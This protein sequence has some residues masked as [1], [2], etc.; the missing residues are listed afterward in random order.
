M[1]RL[2]S[3]IFVAIVIVVVVSYKK[4]GHHD[5]VGLHSQIR[6][7][8]DF[9]LSRL[10]V[11]K[12]RQQIFFFFFSG[13]IHWIFPKSENETEITLHC[14]CI[15]FMRLISGLNCMFRPKMIIND[16]FWSP[17]N[18]TSFSLYFFGVSWIFIFSKLSEKWNFYIDHEFW[19]RIVCF[20]LVKCTFLRYFCE[21][22]HNKLHVESMF[23]IFMFCML[24]LIAIMYLF[25]VNKYDGRAMANLFLCRH[26]PVLEYKRLELSLKLSSNSKHRIVFHA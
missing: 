12:T 9:F 1:S 5:H 17:I 10:F 20:G 16:R 14:E 23:I 4:V 24:N 19:N 2:C 7:C 11:L 15:H 8:R 22:C 13:F 6:C 3:E 18:P 25:C 26:W 21:L